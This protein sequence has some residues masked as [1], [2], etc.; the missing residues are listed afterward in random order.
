MNGR[1]RRK[2]VNSMMA[3]TAAAMSGTP[4]IGAHAG[5]GGRRP[6]LAAADRAAPRGRRARGPQ[7]SRGSRAR[8][9]STSRIPRGTSRTTCG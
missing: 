3:A 1:S 8:A 4:L 6:G 9:S 2:F 5:P 7:A